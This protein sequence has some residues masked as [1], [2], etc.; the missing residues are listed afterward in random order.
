MQRSRGLLLGLA[1]LIVGIFISESAAND[2]NDNIKQSNLNHLVSPNNSTNFPPKCCLSIQ[3]A[4]ESNIFSV[5]KSQYCLLADT[6]DDQA[7]AHDTERM[8]EEH[9]LFESPAEEEE[10]TA[11]TNIQ[12]GEIFLLDTMQQIKN[13]NDREITEQEGFRQ[14]LTIDGKP[15]RFEID[16]KTRSL[17]INLK[18]HDKPIDARHLASFIGSFVP[19]PTLPGGLTFENGTIEGRLYLHNLAL[20]FPLKFRN[21]IFGND[22]H[23]KAPRA[24]DISNSKIDG[25][26][27]FDQSIVCGEI[28]I[29]DSILNR[30]LSLLSINFVEASDQKLSHV[31]QNLSHIIGK[32][33]AKQSIEMACDNDLKI[34]N[35]PPPIEERVIYDTSNFKIRR[36][37]ISGSLH[38]HN[39]VLPRIIINDNIIQSLLMSSF[40]VAKFELVGNSIANFTSNKAW[41]NRCFLIKSNQIDGELELNFSREGSKSWYSQKSYDC[42]NEIIQ[43]NALG[44]LSNQVEGGLTVKVENSSSSDIVKFDLRDNQVANGSRIELSPAWAGTVDL[45]GAHFAGHLKL[46]YLGKT[47]QPIN[48]QPQIKFLFDGAT[49]S[50]L[51]WEFD[52]HDQ[53]EKNFVNW[54]GRG[55]QLGSWQGKH[56]SDDIASWRLALEPRESS[57]SERKLIAERLHAQ[58]SFSLSRDVFMEA[59]KCDYLPGWDPNDWIIIQAFE[60]SFSSMA[61]FLQDS[62]NPSVGQFCDTITEN[63]ANRSS[64]KAFQPRTASFEVLIEIIKLVSSGFLSLLLVLMIAPTGFGVHPEWAIGWLFFFWLAGGIVYWIRIRKVR[65]SL[66]KTAQENWMLCAEALAGRHATSKDTYTRQLL[67]KFEELSFAPTDT[68]DPKDKIL[69]EAFKP[70]NTL[71]ENQ[72]NSVGDTYQSDHEFRPQAYHALQ[73]EFNSW[74]ANNP[75][76]LASHLEWKSPWQTGHTEAPGFVRFDSG[77]QPRHFSVWRY[78]ADA[79][80]PIIDLHAYSTYHPVDKIRWLPVLQHILGWWLTTGLIVSLAIL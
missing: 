26:L 1:C 24:V 59:K 47:G 60:R 65:D 79:M 45:S 11:Q 7:M 14:G 27:I 30:G 70:G 23:P 8:E 44:I 33:A 2:S 16:L 6:I 64:D 69:K 38:L 46:G 17:V 13:L 58:G 28:S 21:M 20:A 9:G 56:Q 18:T 39:I 40:D 36:S 35:A 52:L 68:P 51:G 61:K 34:S 67:D 71:W 10:P 4:D 29:F 12:P 63:P 62:N 42:R 32:R 77:K 66:K 54:Q 25:G 3:P 80:L 43:P 5:I 55:L 73:E 78:S 57:S 41:A 15:T 76:H 50:S 72:D 74:A 48:P 49:I 22:G 75:C 53:P 19:A 37:K 31:N